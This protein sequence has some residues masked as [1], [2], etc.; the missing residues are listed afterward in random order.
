M[1]VLC[2]FTALVVVALAC[3]SAPLTPPAQNEI[4][5]RRLRPEPQPLT[6]SSGI[7]ESRRLVVRDEPAWRQIWTSIWRDVS[8][9]PPLPQIDFTNEMVIVAALGERPTG[10]YAI[11]V[12]GATRTADGLSIRVRAISPGPGCL[13]TQALTQAVDVARLPRLA[14]RVTFEERSET[15]DC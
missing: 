11:L 5:V 15:R 10:G 14:G 8:E 6:T 1:R 7:T 4:A 9:P 3:G 2:I 12:D 13:T